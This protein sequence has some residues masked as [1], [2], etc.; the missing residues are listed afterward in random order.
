VGVGG[1]AGIILGPKVLKYVS[2]MILLSS[3]INHGDIIA[4]LSSPLP[5]AVPRTKNQA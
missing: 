4:Y 5:S 2:H 1:G 3:L